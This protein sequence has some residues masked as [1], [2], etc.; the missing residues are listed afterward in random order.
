MVYQSM[1]LLGF[2]A[3]SNMLTMA[4]S[5]ILNMDLLDPEFLGRVFLRKSI[6]NDILLDPIYA[7][8]TNN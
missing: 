7:V 1:L 4:L 3:N 6:E 8:T 2:P 5:K